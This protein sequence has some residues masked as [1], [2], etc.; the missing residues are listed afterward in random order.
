MVTDLSKLDGQAR[1]KEKYRHYL[2]VAHIK[3]FAIKLHGNFSQ[4]NINFIKYS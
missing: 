2:Y 1:P 4:K 3:I